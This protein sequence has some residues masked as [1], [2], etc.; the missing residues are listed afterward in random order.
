MRIDLFH[1]DVVEKEEDDCQH[2][3][4]INLQKIPFEIRW[5]KDCGEWF[6]YIEAINWGYRFSSAGNMRTK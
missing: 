3:L 1:N 5:F 2:Y 6:I 4:T